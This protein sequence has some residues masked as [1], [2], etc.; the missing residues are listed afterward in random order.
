[1]VGSWWGLRAHGSYSSYNLDDGRKLS[2]TN[3]LA[4]GWDLWFTIGGGKT[5]FD[6]RIAAEG[7]LYD[8]KILDRSIAAGNKFGS[9]DT[10]DYRG[11]LLLG[12]RHEPNDR[13]A[14]A[15]W[16]GV[17]VQYDV[18]APIELNTGD[19]AIDLALK[20][21]ASVLLQLRL[22]AQYQ[23]FPGYMAVRLQ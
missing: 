20:G 18:Q 3:E 5:R 1:Y 15:V 16:A 11:S 2:L 23:L 7:A 4:G 21:G 17:G 10:I 6:T 13:F 22:R 14:M 9:E 19:P 8:T 12:V